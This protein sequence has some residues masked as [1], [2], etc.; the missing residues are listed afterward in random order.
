MLFFGFLYKNMNNNKHYKAI[1]E[2]YG[3]RSAKRSGVPLMNHID[4]GLFI[5]LAVK[6]RPSG[7]G[8]K[9]FAV[10]SLLVRW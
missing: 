6:P 4:E 2:F 7:R 5:P 1:K 9:A 8:Y 3:T 10:F